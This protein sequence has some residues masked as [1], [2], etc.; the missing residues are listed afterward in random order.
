IVSPLV[1]SSTSQSD[2]TIAPNLNIEINPDSQN[3]L[4]NDSIEITTYEKLKRT[5][6]KELTSQRIKVEELEER[7][8]I[9]LKNLK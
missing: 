7:K 6:M 4:E 8:T 1:D 5:M 9:E 2:R 3:S